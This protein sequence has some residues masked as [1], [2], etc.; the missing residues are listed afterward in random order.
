MNKQT[1]LN[2]N[3]TEDILQRLA[4]EETGKSIAQ[5]YGR[6]NSSISAIKTA[7]KTRIEELQQIIIAENINNMR[8][9]VKIDVDNNLEISKQYK[10]GNYQPEAT[11]YKALVTKSIINPMLQKIGIFPSNSIQYNFNQHNQKITNISSSVL[12]MFQGG[13]Q[14]LLEVDTEGDTDV[15]V[16]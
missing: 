9:T 2:K 1:P 11:A 8:E 3:E 14:Q 7:N 15:S 5:S 4:L 10:N 6:A 16:T 12:K 13:A